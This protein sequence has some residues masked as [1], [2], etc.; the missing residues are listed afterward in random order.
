MRLAH[1]AR[2]L[3]LSALLIGAVA[4]QKPQ[5]TDETTPAVGL[6]DSVPAAEENGSPAENVDG[7]DELIAPEI[8]VEAVPGAPAEEPPT[9]QLAPP[10]A[11]P[12]TPT[13]QNEGGMQLQLSN[14]SGGFGG[15]QP[16]LQL[17]TNF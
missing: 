9:L 3:L 6:E 7:N 10:T 14:P 2:L 11:Q 5:P 15:G 16:R 4:C 17:Q 13:A 1:H 12:A 8:P